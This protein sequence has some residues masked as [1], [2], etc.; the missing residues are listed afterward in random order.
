VPL[1]GNEYIVRIRE[2]QTM[3]DCY[4]LKNQT[5]GNCCN[6]GNGDFYMVH[7]TEAGNLLAEYD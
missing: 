5:I 2:N 7:I 4:N 6:L 1:P 3:G